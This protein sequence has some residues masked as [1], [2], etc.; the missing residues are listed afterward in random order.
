MA[1]AF[2]LRQVC[3]GYAYF[4]TF[5]EYKGEAPTRLETRQ[6]S[7]VDEIKFAQAMIDLNQSM[8]V[9]NS[10]ESYQKWMYTQ[11]W[12]LVDESFARTR[13]RRWLR[14]Q[15]CIR[16]ALGS[17]TD[18]EIASPKSIARSL[19]G[20]AKHQIL[21]RDGRACRVCG[22]TS[23]L[24]LQH[25]WPFASGGET[26]SRNMIT[27][28]APCNQDYGNAIAPNLYE[29]AGLL[30]GFEP[31]LLK[32]APNTE[33]AFNRAVQISANLMHSRCEVW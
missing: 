31:A 16:S 12:A 33:E 22:A 11:G 14:S 23:D 29:M 1:Y 13:M 24:T 32:L 7:L 3:G 25:I 4:G 28:C 30:H 2:D 5:T 6:P 17:F 21:E 8:R 9:V 10:D 18:V 15:K 27:L 26:S 20:R 19:R